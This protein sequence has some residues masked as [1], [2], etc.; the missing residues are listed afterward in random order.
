MKP[1]ITEND[2]LKLKEDEGRRRGTPN[3]EAVS[4]Q[5]SAAGFEKM[6]DDWLVFAIRSLQLFSCLVSSRAVLTFRIL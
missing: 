5:E 2:V 1:L 6:L 3:R 4:P